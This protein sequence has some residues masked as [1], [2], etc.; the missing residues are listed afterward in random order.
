MLAIGVHK[1]ATIYLV[2]LYGAIGISGVSL[3][4]L[5]SNTAEYWA[6]PPSVDDETVVY[7]H[8]H[9]PDY[10]GHFHRH[11]I[12]RHHSVRQTS[13]RQKCPYAAIES[14]RTAHRPHAC[15]I[16]TIASKLKLGHSGCC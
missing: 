1:L 14:E 16:L 13:D 2:A 5:A 7:Y 9:G 4:Y 6:I 3:H 10:H 8:V 15:P 12:H 11:T